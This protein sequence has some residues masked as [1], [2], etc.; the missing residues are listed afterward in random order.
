MADDKGFTVLLDFHPTYITVQNARTPDEA[1]EEV[2]EDIRR[3]AFKDPG[4][5]WSFQVVEPPTL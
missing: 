3:G 2:R 4:D 1:I 5:G